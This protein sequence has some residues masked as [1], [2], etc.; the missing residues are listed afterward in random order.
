MASSRGFGF[1]IV[2]LGVIAEFHAQ[3]IQAMRGGRLVCLFSQSV[4]DKVVSGKGV[5]SAY[6]FSVSNCRGRG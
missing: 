5:V 4:G 1:G 6:A 2:G 3:A